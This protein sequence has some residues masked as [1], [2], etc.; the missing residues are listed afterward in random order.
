MKSQKRH[1]F[2]IV[3]TA[4]LL[5]GCATDLPQVVERPPEPFTLDYLVGNWV[6]QVDS[7]VFHE[8]WT[9]INEGFYTGKGF[10]M[11]SDDTTFIEQLGILQVNGKWLYSAKVA[12]QNSDA[13]VS[14]RVIDLGEEGVT[15][16]NLNHDFPQRI[17][18]HREGPNT[19]DATISG[20]T[21][22]HD[23]QVVFPFRRTRPS[24]S[25]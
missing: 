12:G 15:F 2:C 1:L 3:S 14:F 16:E 22:G 11:Q 19:M 8:H 23:H 9:K 6:S 17:R 24:T 25:E 20:S 7:T 5:A 10:V 13:A 4:L 21:D 18:Y